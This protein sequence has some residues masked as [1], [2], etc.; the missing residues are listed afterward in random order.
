MRGESGI[1]LTGLY[2]CGAIAFVML[3]LKLSVIDTWAWWRVLLP[4]GL[5]V[6]FNIINIAVAFTYLWFADIPET[7]SRD[8][9]D[10]LEPHTINAHYVA[11]M[12][13]FVIFGD[14]VVRWIEGSETSHW[15][16]L[17]S[18]DIEVLAGFGVLS[19]LALFAYWSRIGRALRETD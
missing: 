5:V 11:A 12:L 10:V 17:L 13:F 19:V 18:G 9:A 6:G 1:S 15:F 7:P 8:E 4:V 16:W 14:N 3:V 2:I